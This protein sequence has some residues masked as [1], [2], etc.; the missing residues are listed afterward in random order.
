MNPFHAQRQFAI[1]VLATVLFPGLVRGQ[2]A[3]REWPDP[4]YGRLGV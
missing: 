2:P 1:A 4:G 3:V